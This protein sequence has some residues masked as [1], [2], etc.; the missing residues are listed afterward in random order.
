[1]THCLWLQNSILNFAF[2]LSQSSVIEFTQMKNRLK[3]EFASWKFKDEWIIVAHFKLGN[4]D[5]HA[6]G[7]LDTHGIEAEYFRGSRGKRFVRA[8]R[9]FLLL[10]DRTCPSLISFCILFRRGEK[11]QSKLAHI[12]YSVVIKSGKKAF[13]YFEGVRL[14]LCFWLSMGYRII[15]A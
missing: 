13:R 10:H 11:K 15:K 8:V 6:T 2:S 5:N 9:N 3:K 14:C 1:M 4:R 12:S 7:R